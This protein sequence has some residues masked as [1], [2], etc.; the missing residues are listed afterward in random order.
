MSSLEEVLL[1]A[2][3]L[4]T[5]AP[6]EEAK[7]R[8][9]SQH[10]KS[11]V[12]RLVEE[13][14]IDAE[15]DVYGSSARGTWLP[16]QRDIDIFVVLRDR[17]VKPEAVVQILTKR[18]T[19]LGLRWTLRYAQHPY[20][21]LQVESYEVDVVPCYKIQ[22]GE[23]PITAA[24]RSPLHHR[25][26]VEKLDKPRVLDVR[27]LKLFLKTIGI[28]GAEIRSEGFSGY[29]T[30]LLIAYY[31]SFVETLEAASRWRPYRTYIAFTDTNT[32][33]KAPLVVVDPVDPNRNAA[34]AV[35]LT[36]MSTFILAA[37]RFLKKPS[38]SYF[39][40]TRGEL[41]SQLETVEV[42]FPY[43]DEPPDIVWG[44][45]K[46][47]GRGLYKWLRECGFRILRWGVESDEV[48]Y[49]SL[50]YIVENVRLTPYVLHRGPPVYDEAVDAFIEKYVGEEV[51][52]PFVQGSRVYVIKK[53]RY[54]DISECISKKLGVG[55]YDIRINTYSGD[56]VR[57][58]PW[59][60]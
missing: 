9:V 17:S 35:S 31:G 40:A 15:V 37:R 27:L 11:L 25:F 5:P 42:V 44:R 28:Y 29:L 19:E 39:R 48:T 14:G 1:E 47:L 38:L 53:R 22:P 34:A 60:T 18:F 49:V 46:R 13:G 24:D 12:S 57:K 26:L 59:I 16:G 6:A 41:V 50:V 32:K 7:I 33:F 23:R 58:N 51:V 20:V 52:G 43:P 3:K 21:S 10:V 56:L 54:V 4:V 8:E 55:G 45:Y 30:E 36:S 2:Y